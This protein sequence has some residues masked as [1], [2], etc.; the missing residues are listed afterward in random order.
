MSDWK[1]HHANEAEKA[2]DNEMVRN[3]MQ[4]FARNMGFQLDGLPAY[5]LAKV[6]H[7]AASVARAQALGFDPDLLRLS[8]GEATERQLA[9]AEEAALS[10][11]P[12]WVI[13][14]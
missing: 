2:L 9:L 4:E 6:A 3:A 7:Y 10:G 12:V 5:G 14:S 8:A 1:Q 13:E 11:K